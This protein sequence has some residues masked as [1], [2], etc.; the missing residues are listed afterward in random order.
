V[1]VVLYPCGYSSCHLVLAV[2]G[3]SDREVSQEVMASICTRGGSGWILGK[4]LER[5]LMYWYRL[6]RQ[7]VELP[8]L[9]VF[10]NHEDVALRVM[11]SGHG[12]MGW[13]WTW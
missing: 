4:I 11:V 12:G 3:L 9:E 1:V 10:R 13:I 2:S 7:V 6:P 8:P 5:V